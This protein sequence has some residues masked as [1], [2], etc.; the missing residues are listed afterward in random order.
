MGVTRRPDL[1]IVRGSTGDSWDENVARECDRRRGDTSFIDSSFRPELPNG[2]N[3]GRSTTIRS[4]AIP[5]S[6]PAVVPYRTS[7]GY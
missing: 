4:S 6:V 3:S 5:V 2:V 7:I 1:L